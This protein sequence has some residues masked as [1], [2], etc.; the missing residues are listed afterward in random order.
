MDTISFD[1]L[2]FISENIKIIIFGC[3][4]LFGVFFFFVRA[5]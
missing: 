5:S 3:A 1:I 4:L 2:P